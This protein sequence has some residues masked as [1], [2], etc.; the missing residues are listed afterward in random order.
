MG[1]S[2]REQTQTNPGLQ[3]PYRSAEGVGLYS[4]AIENCG[5]VTGVTH[6][7]LPH[8]FMF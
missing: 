2:R 4:K 6:A 3:R 1:W 7:L 8:D 5:G